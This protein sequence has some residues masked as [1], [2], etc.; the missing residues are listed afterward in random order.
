MFNHGLL[1]SIQRMVFVRWINIFFVLVLLATSGVTPA[2]AA[3]NAAPTLD[4]ISN[5]TVAEDSGITTIQLTGISAGVGDEGQTLAVSAASSDQ[6]IL[7]NPTIQYTS[8]EAAGS[9]SF[10]PLLNQFGTVTVTVTV[11]DNGGVEGG[12]IDTF[13]RV[14]QITVNS[15]NDPPTVSSFQKTGKRGYP[16]AFS[17][18]DFLNGY[19]D[20]ENDPLSSIKIVSLPATGKLKLNGSILAENSEIAADQLNQ[21]SFV[22]DTGWYGIT[23]FSWSASDGQ[24]YATS[25]ATAT[26]D[27]PYSLLY[28]FLPVTFRPPVPPGYFVK[29][30]PPNGA[31][32]AQISFYLD[33]SD[34]S[35]VSDYQ[36]CYDAI[37]NNTCDDGWFSIYGSQAWLDS[38]SYATTYEWQVR[39][40]NTGGTTYANDSATAFYRFTTV[41]R[42]PGNFSKTSPLNNATSQPV[43]LYLQWSYSSGANYY[44]YCYDAILNNTCDGGWLTVGA[45]GQQ[46]LLTGLNNAT[47]YEWQVRAGNDVGLTYSDGGEL[48]YYHFTTIAS[49]QWVTSLYEPF[50]GNFPGGW[51]LSSTL[52]DWDTYQLVD[53]TSLVSWGKRSCYAA[54]GSYSGWGT[55]GGS[56]GQTVPCS[57][58]YPDDY[59]GWMIM[60]PYNLSQVTDAVLS[61]N[62]W[63]DT[64]I[65]Y[66]YL[67]FGVSLDGGNFYGRVFSGNSAGWLSRSI[68]LK[69]V[70]TLGNVIG[71]PQVW[72]GVWFSTDSSTFSSESGVAVD[73]LTLTTC[74]L[75]TG[76][77]PSPALS[78]ASPLPEG[79]KVESAVMSR[80]KAASQGDANLFYDPSRAWLKKDGS[81]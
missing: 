36:Y 30:S 67:G 57:G 54:N 61:T 48:A 65:N 23:S 15:V 12:G 38:L 40:T 9:L 63:L 11:Q 74:Y 79:L 41:P 64:E 81:H 14:F 22:P 72:I 26:L 16:L 13:T 27:V 28:V 69:N 60:G 49:Q 71:Q 25:P 44:Q 55:A 3:V 33:W 29:L 34:A 73:D 53:V 1:T 42:A 18:Q 19:S 76:C 8:P 51:Q 39:A 17:A 6:S 52:Y 35:G 24:D 45:I 5:V 46:A 2:H 20:V 43:T 77:G 56:I 68:D 21:L 59:E 4:E 32:G 78:A 31:T 37:L 58:G 66:D 75:A 80:K 47:T 7:P 50:E 10:A 62:I 70:Y